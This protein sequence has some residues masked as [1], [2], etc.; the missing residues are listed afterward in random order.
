M[1]PTDSQQTQRSYD[2]VAVEYAQKL[3]NEIDK[4]PFD[5]KML[6]WL[7][8]R[9]GPHG[10]I[11]DLGCGPG[12]VAEYLSRFCAN[13]IGVD[14]SDEMV[15]NAK[16]LFPHISFQQ[17]NMLH[18]TTIKDQSLDGIA[19]FYS[20]IHIHPSDLKTAFLTAFRVLKPGG[21]MLLS[22]HIGNETFHLDQWWEKE[23]SLDFYFFQPDLICSLLINSGFLVHESISRTPYPEHIEHQSHRAYIFS[24]RPLQ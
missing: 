13:T 8:E 24:Q 2:Q 15:K 9:C 5:Q 20:Y 19:A 6:Q 10:L 12:Q 23:V 3:K 18:L 21:W 14:L 1:T 4:K 17:D 22:F 7:A 16:L 11:C